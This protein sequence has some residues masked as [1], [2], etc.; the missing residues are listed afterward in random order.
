MHSRLPAVV[1]DVL[2]RAAG[3]F[4]SVSEDGKALEG[5]VVVDGLSEFLDGW[6]KPSGIDGN[7]AKRIAEDVKQKQSVIDPS[8][9]LYLAYRLDLHRNSR[10]PDSERLAFSP[11]RVNALM[12]SHQFLF[13]CQSIGVEFCHFDSLSTPDI[14]HAL[15]IMPTTSNGEQTQLPFAGLAS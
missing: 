12:R 9:P 15:E 5:T 11:G 2:G 14:H 4:E 7:G 6:G 10:R 13:I 3:F 8:G 1:Q